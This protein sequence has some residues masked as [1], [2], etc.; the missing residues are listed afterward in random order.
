MKVALIAD[1]VK[2]PSLPLMK[3]SAWH[4]Q[5]GDEVTLI[6]GGNFLYPTFDICY[7][8]QVFNLPDLKLSKIPLLDT[9]PPAH[10]YIF[11]GSGLAITIDENGK[12]IY[13][14]SK[15]PDLP[16]EVE[17][18]Y[19]G[20]GLYGIKNTAYG[21]LTRGCPNNC[22]FC[23]V[24]PKEGRCSVKVADLSE[25]WN[26]QKEIILLDP[27]LLACAERQ[28]LL[29]QLVDSGAHID[30]TQGLDPRFVTDEIAALICRCKIKMLHFSFDLI[31]N[32]TAIVRGLQTFK[33]HCDLRDRALKVYILTNFNSTPEEDIYRVNKVIELGYT[34]DVRI[35]RKGTHP[36][37][38]TDLARWANNPQI[39][40]STSFKKYVPRVDGVRCGLLYK[41]ILEGANGI[42]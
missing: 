36:Q 35:Y 31:E 27:N 9:L 16:Y 7:V 25:W 28:P 14:K 37:F 32:K 1:N 38:L 10:Q 20:Y 42:K 3:L 21:F 40:R 22:G 39:Y 11:G 2:F 13:D 6:T 12:E 34:P 4:K 15:D 30:F 33:R 8:S 17:H 19:P 29:Q 5:K 41:N 26:G 24:T 18:I 23:I